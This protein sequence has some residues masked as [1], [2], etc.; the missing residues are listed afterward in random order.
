MR[1][2]E[3]LLECWQGKTFRKSWTFMD[4]DGNVIDFTAYTARMQVRQNFDS[5][6]VLVELT[7]ENDRIT[8]DAE[9]GRIELFISDTV[10]A[11]FTAGTY[12]WDIELIAGNGD[13]LCPFFGKFKVYREVTRGA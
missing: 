12:R 8:I 1:P 5:E 4:E 11:E 10:T 13:V 7:T 3:E 6:D 9:Y 2:T